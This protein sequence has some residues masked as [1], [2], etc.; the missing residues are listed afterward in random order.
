MT[1]D[2]RDPLLENIEAVYLQLPENLPLS[3]RAMA[4]EITA[5]AETQAEK[6]FALLHWL[7]DNCTYTTTPG[8]VEP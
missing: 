6:A 3:V 8:A 1:E 2:S 5:G 7:E 4:D